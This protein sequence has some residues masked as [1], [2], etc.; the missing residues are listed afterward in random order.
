[1]TAKNESERFKDYPTYHELVEDS[2]TASK[3]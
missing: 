2:G 1:M 3:V